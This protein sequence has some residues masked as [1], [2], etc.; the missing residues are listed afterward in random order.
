MNEKS[1]SRHKMLVEIM[2]F[3]KNATR[4]MESRKDSDSS[5]SIS[6][7]F[8]IFYLED[9][10]SATYYQLSQALP[11]NGSYI[12]KTI[13]NMES[14]GIILREVVNNKKIIR[15]SDDAKKTLDMR[16]DVKDEFVEFLEE[17][18]LTKDDLKVFFT[19]MMKFSKILGNA[20]GY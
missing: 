16:L 20:C 3:Y 14:K 12:S 1:F 2:V 17:N 10:K 9:K 5:L 11:Y 6:D 18:G 15:L 13:K 19:T 8:F 4:F 7:L